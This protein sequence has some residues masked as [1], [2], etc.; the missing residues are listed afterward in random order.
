MLSQNFANRKDIETKV[1][2]L[3]KKQVKVKFL[4]ESAEL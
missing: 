4:D 3:I 1:C 2:N